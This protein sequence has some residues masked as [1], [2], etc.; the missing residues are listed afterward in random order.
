ML[1]G[2]PRGHAQWRT[3]RNC[4]IIEHPSN[5]GDSFYVRAGR[6]R[7]LLRLY[8]VD[9]PEDND[10]FPDR[11]REQ[12]LHF[13]IP[14]SAVPEAG[15]LATEYAM[16]F[17]SRPFTVKTR[18]E[19]ARGASRDPR[20]YALVIGADGRGLDEALVSAGLARVFGWRTDLPDGTSGFDHQRRLLALEQEAR[21]AGRGLWSGRVGAPEVVPE[22]GRVT[23]SSRLVAAHNP[24]QVLGT[25]RAGTRVKILG[26]EP[27]NWARVRI[28]HE[29]DEIEGLMSRADLVRLEEDGR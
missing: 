22:P 12:A 8:F 7:L 9:A 17:L 20:F 27:P 18:R 14:E 15:D 26:E 28:E 19:D 5:D 1:L 24:G 23:R 13:G 4:T 25:L 6:Q 10:R 16:E 3:Y 29:G 2:A 21:R 11:N